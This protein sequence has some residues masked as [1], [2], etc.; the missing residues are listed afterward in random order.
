MRGAQGTNELHI[1]LGGHSHVTTTNTDASLRYDSTEPTG[2]QKHTLATYVSDMLALER[3]ISQPVEHQQHASETA[4]YATASSLINRIASISKSHITALEARLE[5]LGGNANHPLKAA[6]ASLL[7]AGASAVGGSR[8]TKVSKYLRDDHTA[9]SLASIGYTM[10]YTTAVGL[11]DTT[12]AA[13]AK[14]HLG[15]IAPLIIE[16]SDG[17]PTVVLQELRDDGETVRPDAAETVK[18]EL[19][20]VWH[21][22]AQQ[23]HN[24]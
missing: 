19:D 20:A 14:A 10:L 6:W 17:V 2:D 3:H 9:L 1:I 13:L 18:R 21:A 22:S 11:G 23:T 4:N 15:D 8:K 16:I 7:G 12:T 5:E 24:N